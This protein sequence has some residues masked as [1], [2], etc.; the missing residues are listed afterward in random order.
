MTVLGITSFAHDS[1]AALVRDGR[2]IALAEEER[3]NRERRT[4]RFPHEAIRFCLKTAGLGPGD[5]HAVG[6]FLRPDLVRG[7]IAAIARDFFPRALL[8]L[9]VRIGEQLAFHVGLEAG[10]RRARLPRRRLVFVEHH[11]CHAASAFYPSP[12]ERAAILTVDGKGEWAA[13][14]LGIGE[15]GAARILEEVRYPHSLGYLYAAITGFI[16]FR[17][18]SAEGSTMALASFG[19]PTRYRAAFARLLRRREDGGYAV[20]LDR[21]D[22]AIGQPRHRPAIEALLGPARRPDEPL[23]QRHHDVAAALQ[24]AVEEAVLALLRR[25]HALTGADAVCLAGGVCLNAAMNGRIVAESPFASHLFQPLASDQGTAL[26][27]ALEVDAAAARAAGRPVPRVPIEGLHLGPGHD[28][29]R[30]RAAADRAIAAGAPI[31]VAPVAADGGPGGRDGA[32][33]RAAAAAIAAGGAIGWVQGRLEAGPR[34]LG[35]RSIVADP[36]DRAMHERLNVSVKR[37]ELFRPFAPAVLAEAADDWFRMPGAR[38]GRPLRDMIVCVPVRAERA[39]QIPAVVHVDGSA[40]VQV[41]DEAAVPRYRALLAAFG[42]LTGVPIVI[43][44]SFNGRGEP[45]V[46]TPEDAIDCFLRIGL[47]ALFL[48]DVVVTRARS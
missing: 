10:L 4:G 17:P 45:I 5:L 7:R 6:F 37:R 42:E 11:L 38:T 22:F 12:W 43:N 26:G 8:D 27:A 34:A 15:G 32:V 19:D 41:V 35:A 20:C 36:R 1:A 13:T 18:W 40:R 24:E 25:L 2:V 29:A 44:T 39:G 33:A 47:D 3:F 46:A 9:P 48:G 31:R 16:G 30:C 14:T 21:L 23:E 28:D